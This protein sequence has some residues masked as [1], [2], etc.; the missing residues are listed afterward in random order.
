MKP[1][2]TL[3]GALV[4]TLA[5]PLIALANPQLASDKGCYD[6][7]GAN[8]RG[9][10]PSFK[11]LP[12]RLSKLKGDAQAEQKFVEKF[13]SGEFLVHIDAHERLSPESAKAL[14]HWLAE[15]GN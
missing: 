1:F 2:S 4:T 14:V 7:H 9:D 8:L 10:A 13:E 15:G 5:L 6:C 11:R 3:L 12:E